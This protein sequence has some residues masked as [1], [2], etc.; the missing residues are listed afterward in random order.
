MRTIDEVHPTQRIF[1]LP[2]TQEFVSIVSLSTH[3]ELFFKPTFVFG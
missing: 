1:R 3:C 2:S